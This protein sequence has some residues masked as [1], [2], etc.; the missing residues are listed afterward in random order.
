MNTDRRLEE[1]GLLFCPFSVWH[2]ASWRRVSVLSLYK[3]QLKTYRSPDPNASPLFLCRMVEYLVGRW[4][5]GGQATEETKA[6]VD[7]DSSLYTGL[8]LTPCLLRHCEQSCQ[9]KS[10]LFQ[11]NA[12]INVQNL[13]S[14]FSL[15]IH[16]VKWKRKSVKAQIYSK[17]P[18]LTQEMYKS[19]IPVVFLLAESSIFQDVIKLSPH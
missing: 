17:P 7:I 1:E 3:V 13:P 9:L 18:L 4:N 15:T 6:M 5:G 12:S 10:V 19:K 14:A 16:I 2:N 8:F 11:I